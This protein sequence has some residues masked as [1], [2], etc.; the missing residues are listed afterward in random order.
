[1][2][3]ELIFNKQNP[4]EEQIKWLTVKD[5]NEKLLVYAR[6]CFPFGTRIGVLFHK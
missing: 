3:I 1:M 2:K 5:R 4:D 6:Y